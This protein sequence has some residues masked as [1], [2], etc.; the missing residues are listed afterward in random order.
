MEHNV[1]RKLMKHLGNVG[2]GYPQYD[3]FLTVLEKKI[4]PEEAEIALGLPTRLPPFEVEE[5]AVIAQRVKKPVEEVASNLENLAAKGF[6]YKQETDSGKTGYAFIQ[7]GFGLPQIFFWKGEIPEDVKEFALP[8][9]RYVKKAT[10]ENR[11]TDKTRF[12]RYVPVNKVVDN[13]LQAVYT[14]D[15][16]T[17]VVNNAKKIAVVHCPCRQMTRLLTKS[18]CTHSLEVC[19][20]FNKAADFVLEKGYGREI[21]NEEA[22]KIIQKSEEEGLIHF[23]DN[24]QEEIQ[25]CCNCC[26]CCCWNVM[27]IKKGLVPRDYL[28]ATYYLRTTDKEECIGCGQCAE[29]CPL[30]IITMKDDKPAVDESICIGCG[31]CLLNCPTGAAKLKKKDDKT[32]F[33]DFTTLH[34]AAIEEASSKS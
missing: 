20:K 13:A 4:T 30:E 1:Y 12:Y 6:L 14:Y 22:L 29:D 10:P 8:L 18:K 19:L 9:G 7:I 15:M 3:E 28:M 24:C 21:S 25:N 32:P 5:V 31:V 34:R 33:K 26:S 17:E 2:I 27:P 16:I 11:G 23:V